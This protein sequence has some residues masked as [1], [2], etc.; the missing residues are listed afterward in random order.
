MSPEVIAQNVLR[1]YAAETE[2]PRKNLTLP[3]TA[4]GGLLG[5]G[6]GYLIANRSLKRDKLLNALNPLFTG[7]LKRKRLLRGGLGGAAIGAGALGTL[8]YLAS[9]KQRQGQGE[10][11]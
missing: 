8:G 4:T 7:A 6:A 10:K 1:K 9:R 2:A 5:G 3:G 11:A